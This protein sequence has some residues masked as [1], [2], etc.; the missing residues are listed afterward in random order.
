MLRSLFILFFALGLVSCTSDRE[1]RLRYDP[2][3]PTE[4]VSTRTQAPSRATTDL[5][6]G[7]VL[8]QGMIGITRMENLETDRVE[9]SND[10]N[11]MP[12][13]AGAF[14]WPLWGNRIDLGLEAGGSLSFR[15]N[16]GGFY[17]RSGGAVVAVNID[18]FLF[19]LNGGLF[20]STH[21]GDKL[22]LYGGAGPLLQFANYSYQPDIAGTI[23]SRS[24]S[25]FGGGW[26]ARA[27]LEIVVSRAMMIGIGARWSDSQVSLGSGLGNLDVSG[28]QAFVSFTSGF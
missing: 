17:F 24:S 8:A 13:I 14:Q 23:S 3:E 10:F 2:M 27:G 15:T 19:D 4:P 20:A 7:M 26:Y 11:Q 9:G 6:P 21:L 18:T 16:G 12:L 25:G 28:T 22:R 5:V 1:T